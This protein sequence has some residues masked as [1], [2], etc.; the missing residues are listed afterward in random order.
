MLR[1]ERCSQQTAIRI[2]KDFQES[3]IVLALK[4]NTF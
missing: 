3:V 2:K 4:A 1:L